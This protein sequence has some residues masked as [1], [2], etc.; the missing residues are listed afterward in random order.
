MISKPASNLYLPLR[1]LEGRQR[2][3]SGLQLLW[4]TSA[5]DTQNAKNRV[6]GLYDAAV[7]GIE[8]CSNRTWA[9]LG[10]VNTTKML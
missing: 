6:S 3:D 9:P 8:S 1:M 4:I 7:E 5:D 2:K 10:Y